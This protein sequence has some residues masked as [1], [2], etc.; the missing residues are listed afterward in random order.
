[1]SPYRS[2]AFCT[3]QFIDYPETLNGSKNR[4]LLLVAISYSDFLYL[5]VVVDFILKN[6]QQTD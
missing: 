5:Y 4:Q 1:M 3:T 2:I 6:H